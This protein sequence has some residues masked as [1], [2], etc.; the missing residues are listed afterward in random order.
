METAVFSGKPFQKIKF[1][2]TF[3]SRRNYKIISA[4]AIVFLISCSP[5]EKSPEA[6]KTI[7]TAYDFNKTID[8]NPP[9]G[10]EIGSVLASTNQGSLTFSLDQ[11]TPEGAM[12]L[13]RE[14]GKLNVVNP[15]IF[16]FE[17]NPTI[18]GSVTITNGNVSQNASITINLN[19]V[20]DG[21]EKIY[22]GI[23]NLK[24]Q[25]EVDAFGA[26]KYTKITSS[27]NIGDFLNNNPSDIADISS[28]STITSIGNNLIVGLNPQL[29]TL[30][31]L[32]NVTHIT[33]LIF[34]A[35]NETLTSIQNLANV[36]SNY[37]S[38][39]IQKNPNLLN[40]DGLEKID[41]LVSLD[42][43]ENEALLN[44]D[45]L[46]SVNRTYDIHISDNPN[47][48]NI[49]GL[50]S[51]TTVDG[52]LGISN[53]PSLLNIDPLLNLRYIKEDFNVWENESLQ[54]IDGIKNLITKPR[55]VSIH[56]NNSLQS[57][58]GLQG[59]EYVGGLIISNNPQLQN[60]EGLNNI[61]IVSSNLTLSGLG[62]QNLN[63]LGNLQASRTLKIEENNNLTNIEALSKL[64]FVQFNLYINNNNALENLNG[65]E[66][67][68]SIER[69]LRIR[70]NS[71][72]SNFCGLKPLL[73]NNGLGEN[74]YVS[75][76]A[77]NP[78]K[79]DIIDGNCSL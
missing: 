35:E 33:S 54:N 57:I 44:I 30:E 21:E 31:G 43:L 41:K 20:D 79:Q 24:T 46:K 49:N 8:E 37:I 16:D 61:K 45:G 25:A 56:D 63:E 38:V 13:D 6:V 42:I 74:Y 9:Q 68:H 48:R 51:L 14:T 59:L 64:E 29:E 22:F 26:E 10:F 67:L 7:I 60:L 55:S 11:Q 40:L 23:A 58:A 75:G 78:T 52:G 73:V 18:T 19:D 4:L 62:I 70:D 28:L 15:N 17:T 76:N 66:N 77:Y 32:E 2:K 1:M 72:L 34:I 12:I 3:F 5:D 47:L 39:F 69:D 65:L 71:A 53:N 36:S 50:E 27:L